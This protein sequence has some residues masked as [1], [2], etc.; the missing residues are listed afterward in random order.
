MSM[1]WF[2]LWDSKYIL[3][4]PHLSMVEAPIENALGPLFYLY[5]LSLT[6]KDFAFRKKYWLH[7]IPFL[8]T[9]I[10]FIPF[11]AKSAAEKI[12]F[13]I[14]SYTALP[15]LWF[16]FSYSSTVYNTCYI[17]LM[18]LVIARHRR[19]VKKYY[20]STGQVN[21]KWIQMLFAL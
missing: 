17:L 5:A 12:Q 14:E 11:Y 8:L 6:R 21:L 19:T 13:N 3:H 2:V 15:P 10:W 4:V 1:S 16:Y 18:M 9:V 20:S 7:F